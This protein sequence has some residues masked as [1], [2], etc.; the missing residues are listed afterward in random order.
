M[1][2]LGIKPLVKV[3]FQIAKSV[4]IMPEGSGRPYRLYHLVRATEQY[5]AQ[6]SELVWTVKITVLS[7]QA[8]FYGILNTTPTPRMFQRLFA[9]L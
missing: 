8:G 4:R 6:L 1:E 3:P 9:I 2:I 7:N 5:F